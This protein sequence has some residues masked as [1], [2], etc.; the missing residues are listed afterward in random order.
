MSS[1]EYSKHNLARGDYSV[2][3]PTGTDHFRLYTYH[4][5]LL[6]NIQRNGNGGTINFSVRMDGTYIIEVG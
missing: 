3:V 2:T 6:E 5:R 1:Y 4:G